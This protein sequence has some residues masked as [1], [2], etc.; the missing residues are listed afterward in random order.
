MGDDKDSD[1]SSHSV[2]A[3]QVPGGLALSDCEKAETLAHSL[4][5][6]FQRQKDPSEPAVTETVNEA[7]RAYEYAPASELKLTSPSEVPQAIKG[8]KVGK[9]PGLKGISNRVLKLLLNRE[10]TF[11]TKVFNAI[12][13]RQF[14]PTAWKHPCVISILKTGKDPTLPSSYKAISL[15]DIIDK[16]FEKILLS[17]VLKE[18]NKLRLLRDEQLVFRPTLGTTLQ[19]ARLWK[20]STGTLMRRG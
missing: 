9:C 16:L 1:G 11:L 14:F 17:R 5:A 13:Y 18:V 8:I 2:T 10:V 20:E 12:L 19:L 15:L 3:L 6:Q 7:M 4:D